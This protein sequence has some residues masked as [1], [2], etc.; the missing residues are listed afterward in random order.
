MKKILVVDDEPDFATLVQA[1]LRQAGYAVSVAFDAEQAL[2]MIKKNRPHAIVLDVMMPGMDG[3]DLCKLL[4]S[5][6][7]TR[8]IAVIM[9]TAVADHVT[10]TRY[11]H[12]DGMSTEADNYFPK[13][14]TAKEIID[15]LKS[16]L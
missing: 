1:Q 5:N 2:R 14:A 16:L 4:K 9:L 15:S 7:N 6:K 13:P 8:D 12:F 10:N 3:W 11:S